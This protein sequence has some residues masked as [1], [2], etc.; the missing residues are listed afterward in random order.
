MVGHPVENRVLA[1]AGC[2]CTVGLT[3]GKTC[4]PTARLHDEA[5]E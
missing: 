3:Y 1:A 2:G 5:I 4:L